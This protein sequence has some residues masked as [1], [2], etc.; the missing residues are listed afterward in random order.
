M[1]FFPTQPGR[2]RNAMAGFTLIEMMTSV[3]IALVLLLG[4]A[5]LYINGNECFVAMANYQNLDRYSC[6]AMDILSREIRGA[7]AVM[8]D[9]ATS[10]TLTNAT[11]GKSIIINYYPGSSNLVLSGTQVLADTGNSTVTNLTGVVSWTNSMFT[12]VPSITATD[13]LFTNVATPSSCKVIQMSWKC[14]R[15]YVGNAITTESVQTAQI[16][17][18]NNAGP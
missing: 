1:K 11:L 15:T 2:R 13:F 18:R 12:A 9:S 10:I 6:N 3:G 14:Q 17:L 5:I 8:A 7:S 16:V 4:V